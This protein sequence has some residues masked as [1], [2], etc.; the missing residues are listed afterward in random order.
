LDDKISEHCKFQIVSSKQEKGWGDDLTINDHVKFESVCQCH[1]G[2]ELRC[3]YNPKE[4]CY[5]VFL[6]VTGS[7]FYLKSHRYYDKHTVLNPDFIKGG[8]VVM[9]ASL[10]LDGYVS[11]K[12]SFANEQVLEQFRRSNQQI[13][14]RRW[15]KGY[16]KVLPFSGDTYFQ[17]EKVDGISSGSS[18]KYG[19]NC[20]IKHLPSQ[21]YVT[22]LKTCDK[23]ETMSLQNLKVS[24]DSELFKILPIFNTIE[25]TV[26][27]TQLLNFDKIMLLHVQSKKLLSINVK[28][29]TQKDV[30]QENPLS[31]W[32]HLILEDENELTASKSI[33]QVVKVDDDSITDTYHVTSITSSLCSFL[34]KLSH[35]DQLMHESIKD[36]IEKVNIYM[37][38][39]EKLFDDSYNQN[40]GKRLT[41]MLRVFQ[42]VD[43]MMS[44][45]VQLSIPIDGVEASGDVREVQKQVCKSICTALEKYIA[46]GNK[47]SR[48]YMTKT[49][50]LDSLF[51]FVEK[52]F[53]AERVLIA[54]CKDDTDIRD[55]MEDK[56]SSLIKPFNT[57][58]HDVAELMTTLAFN[59]RKLSKEIQNQI[60]LKTLESQKDEVDDDVR[61]IL[62]EFLTKT[63]KYLELTGIATNRL[64]YTYS[65]DTLLT[66]HNQL[67]N[68]NGQH[69]QDMK[70]H[71]QEIETKIYQYLS[72]KDEMHT[73]KYEEAAKNSITAQIL[74][75]LVF[76]ID[77]GY[78]HSRDSEANQMIKTLIKT[79]DGRTDNCGS[80]GSNNCRS[81]CKERYKIKSKFRSNIV[82]KVKKMALHCLQLFFKRH[83]HLSLEKLLYDFK[84]LNDN[85]QWRQLATNMQ[86]ALPEIVIH[87]SVHH[88]YDPPPASMSLLLT[89]DTPI[90]QVLSEV[91]LKLDSRLR[92]YIH[93]A[94]YQNFDICS[95][96][97]LE[98]CD[99]LI[100]LI[101]YQDP[102]ICLMSA[103]LLYDICNVEITLLLNAEQV[104]FH[105]NE[106]DVSVMLDISTMTDE[107][108]LLNKMLKPKVEDIPK[109]LEKLKE[110][111]SLCLSADEEPN[112][113]YQ[114]V[115]YSCGLFNILLEY[116]LEY[117][118]SSH[119]EWRTEIMSSCCSLLQSI[120]RKNPIAQNILFAN[121][122]DLINTKISVLPMVHLINEIFLNN[123]LLCERLTENDI[124]HIFHTATAS[125]NPGHF[126]LSTTLQTIIRSIKLSTTVQEYIIQLFAET[127]KDNLG[128]IYG[129]INKDY[130]IN[131]LMADDRIDHQAVLNLFLNTSDL[132]AT[133][134]EGECQYAD[135]VVSQ[136]FP[137]PDLLEIISCDKIG[138]IHY[139]LPFT[140]ILTW[141]YLNTDKDSS[142]TCAQL[143]TNKMFWSHLENESNLMDEKVLKPIKLLQDT[144]QYKLLQ[145]K[146][147]SLHKSS[148]SINGWIAFTSCQNNDG[149]FHGNLMY[150]I[151][152]LIP[153]ISAFCHEILLHLSGTNDI[154]TS[155]KKQASILKDIGD[156]LSEFKN[157]LE[158]C[159]L[160]IIIDDLCY[161]VE[162]I[163]S[164]C[165]VISGSEVS[166]PVYRQNTLVTEKSLCVAT[167]DSKNKT[168]Q[169]YVKRYFQAY[170][171]Q[172][173]IEHELSSEYI[174]LISAV[175][176][177]PGFKKLIELFTDIDGKNSNST[178]SKIKKLVI[179]LETLIQKQNRQKI[180]SLERSSLERINLWTLQLICGIIFEKIL[181]VSRENL[182]P[183]ELKQQ[184]TEILYPIQMVLLKKHIVEMLFSLLQY[185]KDDIAFQV[186]A[187]LNVLLY[188]GNDET[189]KRISS[190]VYYQKNHE[191]F[192]RVHL[193]LA[194]ARTYINQ[195]KMVKALA[196][197]GSKMP[198]ETEEVDY[199]L[200]VKLL[201]KTQ[202]NPS[203]EKELPKQGK[204]YLGT[205]SEDFEGITEDNCF[206]D[207]R[208]IMAMN[209][210]SWLCNGQKTEIQDM[211]RKERV[212]SRTNIVSQVAYL[213]HRITEE[214]LNENNLNVVQSAL[215]ALIKM[216]AG[217]YNNQVIAFKGQVIRS[218]NFVLNNNF[219]KTIE[220]FRNLKASSIELTE[221]MLEETDEN[222]GQLAQWIIDHLDITNLLKAMLEFWQ[223]HEKWRY[224][225]FQSFHILKRIADY[226]NVTVDALVNYKKNSND[227]RF[228]KLF[229]DD[230]DNAGQ[231]WQYCHH[232][233]RNVEV[234][235]SAPSGTEILTRVYFPYD[236]H[237][238]L[239]EIDKNTILLHVKRNTP[240]E[241]LSDL[242]QWT[243]A[244]RR[245]HEWKNKI[246]NHWILRILL[247]AATFRHFLLVFLTIM[248]NLLVL[249]VIEAPLTCGLSAAENFTEVECND[250]NTSTLL[251][252]QPITS[253]KLPVWYNLFIYIFGGIHLLLALWMVLQYY[254]KHWCNICFEMPIVKRLIYNTKKGLL[255]RKRIYQFLKF[256]NKKF[257]C[258]V[259][260][261]TKP[262]PEK[263]FQIFFFSF[264]PLYRISF[265]LF[266]ILGLIF[267]GYFY[268]GCTL[269]LFLR[270]QIL[271]YI[272]KAVRKS[273]LQLITIFTLGFVITYIYAVF[274]F[275]VMP[276]YF[277]PRTD[278][279]CKSVFECFI[280]ISRLGFLNTLGSDILIRPSDDHP[281]N[282]SVLGFRIIYDLIF[283]IIVTTL[284]LN[285]VVAILVDRFSEIR[286]DRD[287]IE[288]DNQSQC[289]IC[290]IKKD[291]FERNGKDFQKHYHEDHH[292]WNYVSFILYVDTIHSNK[293]NAL[294]KYIAQ[295]VPS[296]ENPTGSI[297]FFPLFKAKVLSDIDITKGDDDYDA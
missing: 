136:F 48:S 188:P 202:F 182:Q 245:A 116:I 67:R 117:G 40:K 139:K 14:L 137:I 177:N 196:Q 224:C 256:L 109:L 72:N 19:E 21:L 232:W 252:F 261:A 164:L 135:S 63:C 220:R 37:K 175:P 120:T 200:G 99:I 255:R 8:N 211:L 198:V 81:D 275:A 269:Y 71:L 103:E 179:I 132:L 235:Y 152:G 1:K 184:C 181:K 213:L 260:R 143:A 291:V 36:T 286:K 100:D 159:G 140:R 134:T 145:M 123:S 55:Q 91:S 280:T 251:Y 197:I 83:C 147:K 222:S 29:A 11:A 9:L 92:S 130:R 90:T 93:D 217:N 107:D 79:L 94:S 13:G 58:D 51:K 183:K 80:C 33:F 118:I 68:V 212:L 27:K 287:V 113:F 226:N 277:D 42:G 290:N 86:P 274:S 228:A 35:K 65:Y 161:C 56:I 201:L 239:N 126:E 233:S 189:H 23:F 17:F 218:I 279:F 12:K 242:L 240:Q 203:S 74:G 2:Y 204:T 26:E 176:T 104:Y 77:Y 263:Y 133:C 192:Y 52:S 108:Q 215:Q 265:L 156:K 60:Y 210:L 31:Q 194:G 276:N 168:F 4:A 124:K 180:H 170:N 25:K 157:L 292:I 141:T 178:N 250:A 285:I 148:W 53:G 20:R 73:L 76:M 7:S 45:L 231:M 41:N 89:N 105:S 38:N 50:I 208:I 112:S 186:L 106:D 142:A 258:G 151:K 174:Y 278:L 273:A 66:H 131:L 297:D 30:I 46:I 247:F 230:T 165:N 122:H 227:C 281:P 216:C 125:N 43:V 114:S 34:Q 39:I 144:Q 219:S 69:H 257:C 64:P 47:K 254:A 75:V 129:E 57:D 162:I 6:A 44:L 173:D 28:P 95:P 283:F 84:H 288:A 171:G 253:P 150:V 191:L 128:H 18:F 238:H 248:L 293:R 138:A 190:L 264:E 10:K 110:I 266:S 214:Y 294:E 237:K 207:F 166:K 206:V 85:A 149:N 221:I 146:L 97:S 243:Q 193:I 88:E 62:C 15:H 223:S 268:C 241:K 24:C 205:D 78:Y 16:F 267:N 102:D 70:K 59:G 236:P 49:E 246:K 127:W 119:S 282:F 153:L 169:V 163:T 111:S 167:E 249:F 225:V 155:L 54:L 259:F 154:R 101:N 160:I 295:Q 82:F 229:K 234:V 244:L 296:D 271:L 158:K 87:T 289:F 61:F 185:P 187:C 115:A 270:N 172:F 209:V 5:R 272:L 96:D 32:F 22:F 262:Q 121:L 3:V 284:G 195:Q 98:L 199:S